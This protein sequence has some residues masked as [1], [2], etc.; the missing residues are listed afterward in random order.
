[1][2]RNNEPEILELDLNPV[3]ALQQGVKVADARVML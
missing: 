3:F 2:L 1:V